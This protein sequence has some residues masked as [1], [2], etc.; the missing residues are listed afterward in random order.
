MTGLEQGEIRL[1][2]TRL[3][4]EQAQDLRRSVLCGEL[5]L[6]RSVV[7]DGRDEDAHVAVLWSQHKPVAT[8]RLLKRGG[9]WV[10]EHLAVLPA[11]RRAGAGRR[12]VDFL[13]AL[14]RQEEGDA[15]HS[16]SPA[17]ASPFFRACGFEPLADSGGNAEII[18]WRLD[19][20]K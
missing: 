3:D 6:D 15:V 18:A 9:L 7:D 1:C 11:H 4:R 16:V 17:S 10:L 13:C 5:H 14:C 8:G 20:Q 19:L 12:L 2:L